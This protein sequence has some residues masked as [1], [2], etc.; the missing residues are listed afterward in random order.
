MAKH[1]RSYT[2]ST[3]ETIILMPP[4]TLADAHIASPA[5]KISVVSVDL[6]VF[7]AS[8]TSP[9]IR[10][11]LLGVPPTGTKYRLNAIGPLK[12]FAVNMLFIIDLYVKVFKFVFVVVRA[13][14]PINLDGLYAML[15]PS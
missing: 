15:A 5:F 10:F 4:E 8:N 2:I 13:I 11:P 9:N 3:P 7:S 1:M 14:G 6:D 12:L